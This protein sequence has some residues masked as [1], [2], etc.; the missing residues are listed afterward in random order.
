MGK[1]DLSA[2]NGDT[3]IVEEDSELLQHLKMELRSSSRCSGASHVS[4]S[5]AVLAEG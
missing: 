2:I 3:L 1:D 5:R 4:L